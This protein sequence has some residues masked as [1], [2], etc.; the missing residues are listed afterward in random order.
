MGTGAANSNVLRKKVEAFMCTN[1]AKSQAP[2]CM[3][4]NFSSQLT[5][6]RHCARGTILSLP[7]KKKFQSVGLEKTS[8]GHDPRHKFSRLFAELQNVFCQA[9]TDVGPSNPNPGSTVALT[10]LPS[11]SG[12]PIPGFPRIRWYA[13]V[14]RTRWECPVSKGTPLCPPH[15]QRHRCSVAA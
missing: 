14:G 12:I 6:R 8:L 4:V 10:R 7:R 3:Y 5:L 2:V 13:C 9:D 15:I 11:F 1:K